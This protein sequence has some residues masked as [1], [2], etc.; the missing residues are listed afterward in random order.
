[1]GGPGLLTPGRMACRAGDG[2]CGSTLKRGA[3]AVRSL[4]ADR[5]GAFDTAAGAASALAVAASTMG[6]TS[7]ALYSL[8]LTAA[9]GA[10]QV[11]AKT[12]KPLALAAAIGPW[13][14]R[15]ARCYSLG[16]TAATGAAR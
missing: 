16:L 8:G 6:G 3:L 13:A 9:A 2:D 15:Q 1:M 7:G 10:A 11:Y 4:L 14:A 5:C 12:Y